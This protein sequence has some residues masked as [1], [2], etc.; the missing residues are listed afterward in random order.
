MEDYKIYTTKSQFDKSLFTLKGIIEGIAI[1]DD[2]NQEEIEELQN[3]IYVNA[4]LEKYKP[5][6]T[7]IENIKCI[8]EDGV[9]DEEEKEDLLWLASSFSA[10]SKY[11]DIVTYSTQDLEGIIHGIMADGRINDAE[12]LRLNNWIDE[13]EFLENT[14]PYDEIRAIIRCVLADG[15]ITED[16]RNRLKAFFADFIDFEVS[17]NLSKS[18]YDELRK[19]YHID[20]VCSIDP[21]IIFE[22][23]GFCV[24]GDSY[25]YARADFEDMIT[26]RGGVIKGNVSSK[27]DYLI[28]G[29]K[30]SECWAFCRYGRKIEKAMELRKKGNKIKI[31]SETD[32]LKFV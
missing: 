15:V 5:F 27:V 26:S 28:V 1:D 8:L 30:G 22:N 4:A 2:I 19:L 32:F 11:Y 31:V 24:T 14:Y 17:A 13:N 16:E 3:W 10:Q 21:Q 6:D 20:G 23:R 7:I 12:I 25:D 29:N 9:I 18:E